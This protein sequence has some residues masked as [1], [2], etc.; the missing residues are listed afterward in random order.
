MYSELKSFVKQVP[1]IEAFLRWYRYVIHGKDYRS[2]VGGKWDEI[3]K[4]QFDFL[5]SQGLKSSHILLDI[6]CG[7]LRG[8]RFFIEYL[9][10]GHYL[11]IDHNRWLIRTG[12]IK[13]LP[14]GLKSTKKPEF[15]ISS[16]FEF[17]KF[18]V[19]PDYALALSLFTH[20]SQDHILLCLSNL[21]KF[22]KTNGRFFATFNDIKNSPNYI[23]PHRSGDSSHFEYAIDEMTQMG[24]DEGWKTKYLGDWGHP[25]NQQMI[26]YFL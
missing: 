23:N 10:K 16:K 17:N 11:G 13:E 2:Y 12:L 20:L 19:Q 3:G 5:V 1:C 22:I 18:S 6:G 21:R 25:R 15:V 8:G 26:E 9:D 24:N 7:S 14:V 4:L